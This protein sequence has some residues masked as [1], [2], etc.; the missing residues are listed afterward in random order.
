MTEEIST[1]QQEPLEPANQPEMDPTDKPMVKTGK[2]TEHRGKNKKPATTEEKK[3]Q[4]EARKIKR[5]EKKAQR[6][7]SWGWRIFRFVFHILWLPVILAGGLALGLLIGYSVLGGEP[8][9]EVFGR[10]L[11]QYLYDIIYAKG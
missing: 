5:L 9:G 8:P 7:K 3:A 6:Q 10:D 1:K 4:R 2:R 11:W